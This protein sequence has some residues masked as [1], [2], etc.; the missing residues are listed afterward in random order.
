MRKVILSV[1]VSLDG[2]IETTNPEEE[3]FVWDDEMAEYFNTF[4]KSLDAFIYGRKAYESMLNYWPAATGKFADIMNNTPKFVFSR[5]L[6]KAEW[7]STIISGNIREEMMKIKS[8]P[9]KD[10]ALFAGAEIACAF[11]K[12]GLIDEFRLIVNPVVLGKG[13]PLFNDFTTKFLLKFTKAQPFNC[14]NVIL[15]Y[16]PNNQ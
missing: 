15:Y 9:G 10:I 1:M 4:F 2:M 3:W 14:G 11:I 12:E 13:T 5:T 7:N 16:Q 6:K 8:Q